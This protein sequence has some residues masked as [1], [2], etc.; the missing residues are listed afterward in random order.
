MWIFPVIGQITTMMCIMLDRTVGGN[1][2]QKGFRMVVMGNQAV[3][4]ES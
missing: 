3:S 2:I 4:Q 1:G